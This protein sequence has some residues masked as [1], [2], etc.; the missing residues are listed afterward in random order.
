MQSVFAMGL[1]FTV[2]SGCEMLGLSDGDGGGGGA[3]K[4]KKML[5]PKPPGTGDSS[6]VTRLDRAIAAQADYVYEP[7]GPAPLL[8]TFSLATRR[9]RIDAVSLR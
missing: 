3:K 2:L 5:A 9:W 8:P 4:E 1:L 7:L 6:P